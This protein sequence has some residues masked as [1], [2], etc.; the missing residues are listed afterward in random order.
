MKR[1]SEA[2]YG[3]PKAVSW[4]RQGEGGQCCHPGFPIVYSALEGQEFD[5]ELL[6]AVESLP[7]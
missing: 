6:H 3:K 4:C 5:P 1:E 7:A 2:A